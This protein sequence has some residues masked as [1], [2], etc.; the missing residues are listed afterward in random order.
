MRIKFKMTKVI[1]INNLSKKYIIPHGNQPAYST[2][3]ETLT[4]KFKSSK[5]NSQP[6]FEEFW[7]LK[8]ITLD[9]QEGDCVGIIG[10]NGAG[11]STLLKI[12]SRITAPTS[13]SVRIRGKV[14][15]LL[16]VGTGFHLELTGRENIFLNGTILGMRRKEIEKKFDEIVAFS[17]I[18]QFLDTPVKRYSSGM[19]TRLGFAIAAH[20]DPDLLIVDEVL[21][22]GDSAFQE[23]CLKKLNQLGSSGRTVL[24]V[25]H[26]VG[27]ILTLCKKG[28]YLE[29]GQIKEVGGI[30]ECVNAYMKT[31]KMHD[32]EWNGD[33][34]DESLRII[35]ARIV[36]SDI[37]KDFFY[38]GDALKL[39][40]TYKVLKPTKDL[41]FGV[42]IWNQRQQ[43]LGR[44]T[45]TNNLDLPGLHKLSFQLDT[46]IFHEGE[47]VI[48][49]ECFIHNFKRILNDEIL[50]KCPI[51]V[52]ERDTR[53]F[54]RDG[55]YLGDQW[56]REKSVLNS[57]EISYV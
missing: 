12:L 4:N 40:I 16:E 37:S 52:P 46:G 26:D 22:V 8:D 30:E 3:I 41:Y 24:F 21:A 19:F 56:D 5:S 34:G 51:Y 11:K 42:G 7:A 15:S 18:E 25:S 38:Q 48:K 13:G 43:L 50:L 1:E 32:F 57:D 14:S 45:T 27:S 53:L 33:I 36:K 47:Y 20:L 39:E 9:I 54:Y 28:I 17:E 44:S 31:C 49:P 23:K 29:K 10:K 2:L 35:S 55:V 6:T